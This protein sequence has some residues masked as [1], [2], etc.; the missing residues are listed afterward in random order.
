M[1]S[2]L[3]Y[4]RQTLTLSTLYIY[5]TFRHTHTQTHTRRHTQKAKKYKSQ[6]RACILYIHTCQKEKGKE[7]K[8]NEK[9]RKSKEK[10][11]K[12][13]GAERKI[14]DIYILT[15]FARRRMG[16]R[17]ECETVFWISEGKGGED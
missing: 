3:L 15:R 11:G 17:G 9:A 5:V 2:G 8:G 13:K 7:E 12:A 14:I 16:V 4:L 10:Q 6:K 1:R